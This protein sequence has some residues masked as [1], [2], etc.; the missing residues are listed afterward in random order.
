MIFVFLVRYYNSDLN[1]KLGILGSK[2]GIYLDYLVLGGTPLGW[3]LMPASTLCM[4]VMTKKTSILYNV[5]PIKTSMQ[6][7]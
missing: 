6:L 4:Q 7:Y 5:F 3:F 2:C 1:L